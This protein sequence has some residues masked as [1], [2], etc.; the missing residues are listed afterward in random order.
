VQSALWA[1]QLTAAAGAA[2]VLGR[3]YAVRVQAAALFAQPAPYV[4][5]G[6][7][8][9]FHAGRPLL[10]FSVALERGLPELGP[11]LFR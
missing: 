5:I 11:G 4:T 8:D 10:L 9:P 3:A 6:A 7:A 1:A 2:I